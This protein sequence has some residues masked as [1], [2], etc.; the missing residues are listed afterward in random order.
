MILD[1]CVRTA[2][3][4]PWSYASKL[5]LLLLV[6]TRIDLHVEVEILCRCLLGYYTTMKEKPAMNPNPVPKNLILPFIGGLQPL[7]TY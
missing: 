4:T 5:H 3:L 1:N 6:K 2:I 7:P